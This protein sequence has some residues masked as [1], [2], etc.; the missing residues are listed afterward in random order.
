MTGKRKSVWRHRKVY[1]P[2]VTWFSDAGIFVSAVNPILIKDFGDDSLRSPKTD[3][4]DYKKIARYTLDRWAKLKQYGTMDKT[5][6][7]LKTMNH[8]FGF[9]MAQKIVMKNNLIAL[10]DQTYPGANDF[11]DSPA[12]SDGSQKWVDFAHTYWHVDYVRCKSPEAFSQHYQ[13]W[14]KHKGCNH[15]IPPENG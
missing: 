11:F 2:A 12:R 9:Y 4:A 10:L 8:Q 6:S 15:G 7:Q 5:S 1:E 13:N 3:K 14:C